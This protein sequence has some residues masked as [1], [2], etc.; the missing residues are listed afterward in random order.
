MIPYSQSFVDKHVNLAMAQIA[1]VHPNLKESVTFYDVYV[2]QIN[3]DIKIPTYPKGHERQFQPTDEAIKDGTLLKTFVADVSASEEFGTPAGKRI[4]ASVKTPLSQHVSEVTSR[5][6]T[7]NKRGVPVRFNVFDRGITGES[8]DRFYKAIEAG[9][10]ELSGKGIFEILT[11]GDSG[12]AM[13]VPL[14]PFWLSVNGERI[15]GRRR[16][17]DGTTSEVEDRKGYFRPMFFLEVE[18][19]ALPA[20]LAREVNRTDYVSKDE[21]EPRNIDS[22]QSDEIRDK[23]ND[24]PSKSAEIKPET[25]Q[26]EQKTGTGGP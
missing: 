24:D 12:I 25:K 13:N 10:L 1:K 20:R 8:F 16:L 2:E 5:T 18:L 15:K 11:T 7:Y 17:P 6:K 26:E 23:L 14:E 3:T 22:S 19:D 21:P 4:L 9:E